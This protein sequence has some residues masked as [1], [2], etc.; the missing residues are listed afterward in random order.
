MF[1]AVLF[2]IAKKWEQS[3]CPST[4]KWIDKMYHIYTMEYYSAIKRSTEH[5]TIQMN[6]ENTLSE[7]SQS[8]RTTYWIISFIR[9]ELV[10]S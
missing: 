3:K 8:Q 7:K 1:I 6:L 2:I 4:D 9:P 10:Y 5:A